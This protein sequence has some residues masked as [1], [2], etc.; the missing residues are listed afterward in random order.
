[1]V[2]IR[3]FLRCLAI[4]NNNIEFISNTRRS[5]NRHIIESSIL[6]NDILLFIA[7]YCFRVS[8]YHACKGAYGWYSGQ[9]ATKAISIG[10]YKNQLSQAALSRVIF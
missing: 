3:L 1:M 2:L 6:I 9:L 4:A 5:S 10:K 8:R 7:G